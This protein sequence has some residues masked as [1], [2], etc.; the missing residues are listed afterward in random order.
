MRRRFRGPSFCYRAERAVP[1]GRS[2]EARFS[3]AGSVRLGCSG[4]YD[5]LLAGPIA[6]GTANGPGADLANA[7][8]WRNSDGR[9]PLS[10]ST[11]F[12]LPIDAHD[13]RVLPFSKQ[14]AHGAR[15][16]TAV[17]SCERA[18]AHDCQVNTDMAK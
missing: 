3:F 6:A 10:L 16:P 7:G 2:I 12:A 14:H 4:R 1:E 9:K 8:A 18:R 5:L 17:L 15:A 11:R 13:S